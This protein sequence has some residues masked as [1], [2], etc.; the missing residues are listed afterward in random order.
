LLSP[1]LASILPF[2]LDTRIAA[3]V[4]RSDRWTAGEA[5]MRAADPARFEALVADSRLVEDNAK[6]VT[7]CRTSAVR[8]G[9]AQRCVLSVQPAS[10]EGGVP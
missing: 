7:A 6:A 5:M 9:K 3:I 8:T 4:L 2:E 10:Q 1:L